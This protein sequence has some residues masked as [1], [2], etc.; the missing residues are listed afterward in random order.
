MTTIA[1]GVK[2]RSWLTGHRAKLAAGRNELM[3]KIDEH[4]KA[5][6]TWNVAT[7]GCLPEYITFIT[8]LG[9][10]KIRNNIQR[11]QWFREQVKSSPGFT[12]AFK[13]H[14][15]KARSA[16]KRAGVRGEPK[17]NSFQEAV[18]TTANAERYAEAELKNANWRMQQHRERELRLERER[19]AAVNDWEHARKE[20]A[21]LTIK[22]KDAQLASAYAREEC[23][24]FEAYLAGKK[25]NHGE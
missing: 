10:Y 13:S 25:A 24:E 9:T 22:H 4:Y 23:A 8:A 5:L 19:N 18:V 17:R 15:N 3:R 7:D 2:R 20:V 21:A 1:E 6:T 16:W 11:I 14:A 12:G